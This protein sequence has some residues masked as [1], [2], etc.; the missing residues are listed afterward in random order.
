MNKLNLDTQKQYELVKNI[1][2][3]I[4]KETNSKFSEI[5]A[6][7]LLDS[8]LSEVGD[9]IYDQVLLQTRYELMQKLE[10]ILRIEKEPLQ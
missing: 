9:S 1:K 8:I 5:Q 2:E 3:F 6:S 7:N 4:L 10:K